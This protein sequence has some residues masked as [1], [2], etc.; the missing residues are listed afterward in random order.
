ML[1]IRDRI[2]H[3]LT[4]GGT[5][6]SPVYERTDDQT[7]SFQWLKAAAGNSPERY[8][9]ISLVTTSQPPGL[10]GLFRRRRTETIILKAADRWRQYFNRKE[11]EKLIQDVAPAHLEKSGYVRSQTQPFLRKRE[12]PR[13]LG[14]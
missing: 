3:S 2:A 7:T 10:L 4:R 13:V 9:H 11:A 12:V 6:H 8:S 5:P 14:F 1:P